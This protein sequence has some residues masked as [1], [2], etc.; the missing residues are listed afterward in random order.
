VLDDQ[1]CAAARGPLPL[2]RQSAR[3]EG[4]ILRLQRLSVHRPTRPPHTGAPGAP[5]TA[6]QCLREGMWECYGVAG[7]V[8]VFAGVLIDLSLLME[9]DCRCIDRSVALDGG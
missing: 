1:Q 2:P 3:L 8:N 9:G 4:G 5:H 7:L 6:D